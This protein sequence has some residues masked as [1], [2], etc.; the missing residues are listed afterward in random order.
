MY[1]EIKADEANDVIQHLDDGIVELHRFVPTTVENSA[2]HARNIWL[3]QLIINS[4]RVVQQALGMACK[5]GRGQ[6]AWGQA[7]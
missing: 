5:N 3:N 7:M 6:R 2:R 1:C 4:F